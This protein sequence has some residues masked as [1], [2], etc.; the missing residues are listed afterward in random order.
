[1]VGPAFRSVGP[2]WRGRSGK[3]DAIYRLYYDDSDSGKPGRK[4]KHVAAAAHRFYQGLVRSYDR[5]GY[6][7]LA[8]RVTKH[9]I[10]RGAN[11]VA[12]VAAAIK[13]ASKRIGNARGDGGSN[14][15]PRLSRLLHPSPAPGPGLRQ[16]QWPKLHEAPRPAR[17]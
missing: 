3:R 12:Y 10:Y 15:S 2:K 14:C 13:A 16:R 1:M 7:P 4:A 5:N 6:S 11:A 8:H 17:V 9:Q